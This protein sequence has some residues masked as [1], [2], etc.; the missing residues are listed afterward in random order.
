MMGA[1]K[2]GQGAI[3]QIKTPDDG[4]IFGAAVFK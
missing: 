2:Q 1:P 4:L 3:Y